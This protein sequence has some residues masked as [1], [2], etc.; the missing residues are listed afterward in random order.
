MVGFSFVREEV[1]HCYGSKGNVSVDPEVI[2]T[3]KRRAT[4]Y[5]EAKG[6]T[7]REVYHLEGVSGKAVSEHP[8][9]KRMLADIKARSHF[10]AHLFKARST[11]TEYERATGIRGHVPRLRGRSRLAAGVD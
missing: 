3:L 5:A 1:A 10:G 2:L 7:V 6:W 11:R 4:H 8:E 9:T